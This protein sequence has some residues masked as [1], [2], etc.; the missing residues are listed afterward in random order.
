MRTRPRSL[1]RI[2]P[3]KLHILE[4]E[5]RGFEPLS[6]AVQRRR[7]AMLELSRTR[8]MAANT[9]ILAITLF[10][11]FQDI[12]LGCCTVAAHERSEELE[13][14]PYSVRS[15]LPSGTAT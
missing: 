3:A 9:Y 7:Q 4:V 2:S 15:S 8:K 10:P 14:A 11:S 12:S 6:S 5:P 1:R 13:L